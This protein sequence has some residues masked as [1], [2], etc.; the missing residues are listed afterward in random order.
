MYGFNKVPHLHQ[1]VLHDGGSTE[2]WEFTNENFQRDKPDLLVDVHRKVSNEKKGGKGEAEHQLT[3]Y[4]EPSTSSTKPKQDGQIDVGTVMAGF[5]QIQKQQAYIS[6]SLLTLQQ[7]NQRLW[8]EAAA[9]RERHRQHEETIK[10]LLQFVSSVYGGDVNGAGAFNANTFDEDDIEAGKQVAL[11]P[12]KRQLMLNNLGEGGAGYNGHSDSATTAEDDM[13]RFTHISPGSQS[14]ATA[15]NTPGSEYVES[16]GGSSVPRNSTASTSN[17]NKKDNKK[18]D[19]P[20]ITI[21]DLSN[22]S[23]NGFDNSKSLISPGQLDLSQFTNLL[24]PRTTQRLIA[25]NG[26]NGASDYLNFNNLNNANNTEVG[27]LNDSQIGTQRSQLN[28]LSYDLDALQ[29]SINTVVT[30][31]GLN[32]TQASEIL[33][34]SQSQNNDHQAMAD[35]FKG[36]D[37]DLDNLLRGINC[38]SSDNKDKQTHSPPPFNFVEEADDAQPNK[39]MRY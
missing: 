26:N 1:G 29:Q 38:E 25:G 7:S 13:S 10:K 4:V 18:P 14:S 36:Y 21:P 30:N 6:T 34:A 9:A 35:L 16:V 3:N 19:S 20:S 11:V 5:T 39:K 27:Q 8:Q 22:T 28:E 37:S 24:S 33:Q 32:P 31:M 17:N 2:L 23:A 12:K 15:T